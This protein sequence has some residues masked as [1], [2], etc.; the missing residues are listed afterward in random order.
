MTEQAGQVGLV[1]PRY[2]PAIGGIERHVEA[3]GRGLL[4]LGVR[5][6]VI[7]TDP[8]GGLPAI[9]E[10]DGVLVRR[11][12]TIGHDAVYFLSPQLGWWLLRNASRFAVL[13][14]HSYHSPLALQAAVASWWNRVPLVVTP[15]YNGM[16]HSPLRRVLH[17]SYRPFGNW[18]IHRARWVICVSEAERKLLEQHFGSDIPSVVVP[19]GVEIK[20]LITTLSHKKPSGRVLV[21]AVGRLERY[22]GTDRVIAALPYLPPEYDVVIV[23][24]G[25][26]RRQIERLAAELGVE[27]QLRMVGQVSDADLLAWY[28]AADIFVSLSQQEAFGLAVL[29]AAV[30]GASVVANDIP[31]YREVAGYV[32]EGKVSFVRPDCS[33]AELARAI[34][35]APRCKWPAD[36]ENWRLPTWQ[37]MVKGTMECYRA[38]LG[39][40]WMVRS[41]GLPK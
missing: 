35:A 36:A 38:M 28:R 4:R 10:R 20:G 9:E 12:P 15:H 27:G 26:A 2:P 8:T 14:A 6:E 18:L 22:K 13:H 34:Q 39:H 23:G 29:E 3:L 24:D 16:G 7:T 11:F 17:W 19:N 31:A 30:A 5:V 41:H 21:L 33:P 25:P 32:P 1:T 37:G 40:D